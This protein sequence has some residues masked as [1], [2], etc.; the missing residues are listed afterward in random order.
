LWNLVEFNLIEISWKLLG[1]LESFLIE[2][3]SNMF[4]VVDTE[5]AKNI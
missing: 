2:I 3:T 1:W 4:K 5:K